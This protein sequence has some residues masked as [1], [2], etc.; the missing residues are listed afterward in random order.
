MF[1]PSAI[2]ATTRKFF[3]SNITAIKTA[4][5]QFISPQNLRTIKVKMHSHMLLLGI[6]GF[7]CIAVLHHTWQCIMFDFGLS[8]S[9]L[10][11][12]PLL[13]IA[14]PHGK[15]C[16]IWLMLDVAL[17]HPESANG[18]SVS[19]FMAPYLVFFP[20]IWFI[21]SLLVLT[22][23]CPLLRSSLFGSNHTLGSEKIT[24]PQPQNFPKETSFGR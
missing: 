2:D 15:F 4:I 8:D 10:M 22:H 7:P 6:H 17:P 9:C 5:C 11:C 24:W 19:R 1:Q 14:M 16:S 23:D 13:H 18:S 3:S 12:N 20:T 21:F